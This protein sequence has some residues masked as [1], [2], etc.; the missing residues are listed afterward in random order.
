MKLEPIDPDTVFK[1][2]LAEK[3]RLVPDD[4]VREKPGPDDL[5]EA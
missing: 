2:Y 3:I 1:S 4:W 5:P